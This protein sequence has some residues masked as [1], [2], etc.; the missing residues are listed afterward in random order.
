MA[1]EEAAH[2]KKLEDI[3]NQ[4]RS[5]EI[6]LEQRHQE[7]EEAVQ[8]RREE[9][10]TA[11]KVMEAE[12]E[13]TSHV[14]DLEHLA[15]EQPLSPRVWYEEDRRSAS[16]SR[17]LCAQTSMLNKEDAEAT[18]DCREYL[19]EKEAVQHSG[20][21]LG[22][23]DASYSVP[24]QSPRGE[25]PASPSTVEARLL[26]CVQ[27][28]IANIEEQEPEVKLAYQIEAARQERKEAEE[29]QRK[30]EDAI[31]SQHR[32]KA[33]QSRTPARDRSLSPA[34]R[35]HRGHPPVIK[36]RTSTSEMEYLTS[37]RAVSPSKVY[38]MGKV[39]MRNNI[40]SQLDK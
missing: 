35:A 19:V 31:L 2:Q 17:R 23:H 29:A 22:H 10:L 26:H 20:P 30:V 16:P 34:Q 7:E 18:G 1:A 12:R 15:K 32:L 5:A 9:E 40:L 36:E 37:L 11:M 24:Y 14:A 28:A 13:L 4:R 38:Q 39:K 6:E 27:E 3:A 25:P 8:R 21:I 33:K